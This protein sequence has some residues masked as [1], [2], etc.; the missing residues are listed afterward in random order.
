MAEDAWIRFHGPAG[1]E[2][3]SSE[4]KEIIIIFH[5][6]NFFKITIFVLYCLDGR[7]RLKKL[8]NLRSARERS[9]KPFEV[10]IS[11]LRRLKT[12][13]D[14]TIDDRCHILLL[15]LGTVCK[16]LPSSGQIL[17]CTY[18]SPNLRYLLVYL[19]AKKTNVSGGLDCLHQAS[20]EKWPCKMA[21][22]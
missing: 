16:M 14:H 9:P 19:R 22:H 13:S 6:V 7:R 12:G 8:K 2:S 15:R 11:C 3:G 17:S 5:A 21:A 10:L 18:N 4:D 20:L 1:A